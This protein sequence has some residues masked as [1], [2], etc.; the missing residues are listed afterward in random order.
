M[1]SVQ[2]SLPSC[3]RASLTGRGGTQGWLS[4]VTGP[5]SL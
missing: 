4:C 1:G 5:T 2:P 3:S